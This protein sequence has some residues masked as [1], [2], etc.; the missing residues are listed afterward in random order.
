VSF[1]DD[2]ADD[3]AGFRPPP[4]P[5]DRIWRHP[6]ESVA[7]RSAPADGH[8]ATRHW[9]GTMAVAAAGVVLIAAGAGVMVIGLRERPSAPLPVASGLSSP[10]RDAAKSPGPVRI[11]GAERGLGAIIDEEGV[12]VTDAELIG[13][14]ETVTVVLSDGRL[15]SGEVV[16][17]DQVTGL[18]VVS[19]PPG[20]YPTTDPSQDLAVG[21]DDDPS[22]I[23]PALAQRVAEDFLTSGRVHH[24][25]L[26]INGFDE[27]PSGV[28]I[29]AVLDDSPADRASLQP[30]D[31]IVALDGEP[32]DTMAALVAEL[33]TR[34]PGDEVVVSYR[35][36]SPVLTAEV[37]VLGERPDVET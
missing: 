3:P 14:L 21:A 7:P 6:S 5:D 10:A 23:D 31:V 15:L 34:S 18:A 2:A 28:G 12:V 22:S 24:A 4:H 9:W 11:A 17:R 33:Q 29:A 13:D 25:W 1:D 35:R 30:G 26:G 32:I 37:I 16:G 8:K 36:A 19:L 27:D 20:D